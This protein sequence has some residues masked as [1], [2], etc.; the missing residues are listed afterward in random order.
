M[1]FKNIE[2]YFSRSYSSAEQD[3][4]WHFLSE[5]GRK[6]LPENVQVKDIMDTWTLQTG[7]PVLTVNRN[8]DED[9]IEFRQEKFNLISPETSESPKPLWWIPIT[10]THGSELIFNNTRPQHWVPRQSAIS[11][12]NLKVPPNQWILVNIQQT[13]FYRV[14]YDVRN[15]HLIT[16][17]LMDEKKFREIAPANRAQ[18]IDD[19]MNLA[20]AGYL[21]YRIALNVTRYLKHETDYVPLSA[22]IRAMDFLDD[23]LYSSASYSMFK[24][25]YL[26][27][28]KKVYGMVG[29]D[30]PPKSD[31]LTVYKRVD[32][33]RAVCHLGYKDCIDQSISLFHKW[34]HE[35][36]PDL[37]NPISA[38]LREIVYCTAIKYGDE[39]Y[40]E[41]AWQRYQKSTAASEKDILLGSLGCTREPWILI[42][43]MELALFPEH[44]I[45]KQDAFS[46]FRAVSNNPI[47][48]LLAFNFIR[49]NWDRLKN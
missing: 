26:T 10:Y 42:R 9:A 21:D 5:A 45:R 25:Y 46:V 35:A 30:D 12:T 11:M 1:V 34:F 14:S 23:M 41:F 39:S 22:A 18:L 38:N 4:L 15:W 16:N 13:G 7:F 20:R 8:Y 19:A 33:L 28:L 32:V 3:E 17:H 36:N 37:N 48:E 47:G 2:M 29:F 44:G 43:F 27:R 49:E 31:L 24:D 6:V 40:W